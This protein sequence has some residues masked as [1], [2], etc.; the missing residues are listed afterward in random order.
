MKTL[1]SENKPFSLLNEEDNKIEYSQK[2]NLCCGLIFSRLFGT[3][4]RYLILLIT[5]LCMSASRSNELTFNFTVICMTSNSSVNNVR[6][7]LI[8]KTTIHKNF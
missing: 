7:F 1:D 4:I 2:N 8:F 5:V 6:L 3:K